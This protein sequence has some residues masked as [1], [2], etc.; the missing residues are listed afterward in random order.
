VHVSNSNRERHENR[1]AGARS[2]VLPALPGI[3]A[4]PLPPEDDLECFRVSVFDAE[5]FSLSGIK[6]NFAMH[7]LSP[8]PGLHYNTLLNRTR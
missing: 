6:F 5:A 4:A 7:V 1:A 2:P 3:P 8:L